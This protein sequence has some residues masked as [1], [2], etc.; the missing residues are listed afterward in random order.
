MELRSD[1]AYGALV[2]GI[3]LANAGLGAAHGFAAGIG[4]SHEIPHGLLCAV[5]LPRVLEYNSAQIS[6][7][8]RGLVSGRSGDKDPVKWLSDK[9]T[10]LLRA[11]A[12]PVDLRP[13]GIPKTTAGALAL[14]SSGSSM[15]GNPREMDA[16]A[17]ARLISGLL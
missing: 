15:S 2:S 6:D 13:Y 14:A 5:F 3:A 12:L 8:I 1:A 17:G 9:V 10:D 11:Y 4:G 7:G 16:E